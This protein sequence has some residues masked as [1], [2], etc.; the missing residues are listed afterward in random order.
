MKF[1]LVP[2]D[3]KNAVSLGKNNDA[4]RAWWVQLK[5]AEST[6]K[7]VRLRD[8]PAEWFS[9]TDESAKQNPLVASVK[10]FACNKLMDENKFDEAKAAIEALLSGGYPVMNLHVYL[11]TVDLIYIELIGQNR[12]DI[13]AGYKTK[14]FQAFVASMKNFPTVIRYQY[15]EA[16]FAGDER[17]ADEKLKLFHKIAE[18]YPYPSDICAE[19]E[20]MKTAFTM[21]KM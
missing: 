20:L 19:E 5:M 10:V 15:A 6:A 18:N 14:E 21:Y 2:N 13:I 7:G 16:L 9:F 11:L 17:K 12:A 1:N 4:V 8:M 3:G